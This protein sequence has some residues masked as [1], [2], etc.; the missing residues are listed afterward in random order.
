M[1][2]PFRHLSHL[3]R[4]GKGRRPGLSGHGQSLPHQLLHLLL[5]R[6]CAARQGVLQC[7]RACL[8]RGGLHGECF[9]SESSLTALISAPLSF[10]PSAPDS[11]RAFSRPRRSVRFVVISSWKW[12]VSLSLSISLISPLFCYPCLTDVF[13]CFIRYCR[14]WASHIIQAAFAA[15]FATNASTG[16]PSLWTWIT[17]S[18]ASTTIIACLRPSAPAAA[19]V[20]MLLF[21]SLPNTSFD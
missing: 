13:T 10:S 9:G 4:E 8:L 5:L 14:P 17:R 16:C 18:T 2:Y 6:T 20:S 1:Y 19:R 3:R 21:L 11:I 15:A 12:F 7:A